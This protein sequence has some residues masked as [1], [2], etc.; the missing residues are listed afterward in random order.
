[1]A[2]QVNRLSIFLYPSIMNR[3]IKGSSEHSEHTHTHTHGEVKQ[4]KLCYSKHVEGRL[5]LK[6]K[7]VH[8][9]KMQDSAVFRVRYF[10]RKRSL[11][12]FKGRQEQFKQLSI[13]G[14]SG[15]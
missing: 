15:E 9:E 3:D 13:T 7:S 14:S 2:V 10:K 6:K 5:P 1:M 12:Y 8:R 4:E 11:Q